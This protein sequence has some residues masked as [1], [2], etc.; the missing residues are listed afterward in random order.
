MWWTGPDLADAQALQALGVLDRGLQEG[1]AARPAAARG[2]ALRL[3]RVPDVGHLQDLPAARQA[4]AA[5]PARHQD[6]GPI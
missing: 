1:D 3:R 5:R 4:G 6:P 2:R